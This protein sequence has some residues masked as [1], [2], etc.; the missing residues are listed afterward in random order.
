MNASGSRVTVRP[1]PIQLAMVGL[2]VADMRR[3]LDFYRA[4]GLAGSTGKT[5]TRM[6]SRMLARDSPLDSAE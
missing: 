1:M 4:L 6:G 5:R 3:S 2:V